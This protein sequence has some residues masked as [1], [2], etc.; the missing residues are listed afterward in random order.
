M[1]FHI[2]FLLAIIIPLVACN[3][4]QPAN[5]SSTEVVPE[6]VKLMYT[7]TPFQPSVEYSD[8]TIGG[9][10]YLAGKFAF[11]VQGDSYVLGAQSPD[12]DQKMCANSGKGQHIH[13]I[14]DDKPYAAKYTSAFDYEIEDG[15]HYL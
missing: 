10:D 2:Y 1:R 12:V 15:E 5:N 9:M 6:E 3:S 11:D 4:N 8:A 14:V 13:L 7:I